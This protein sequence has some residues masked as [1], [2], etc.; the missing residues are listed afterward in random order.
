VK[1]NYFEGDGRRQA[2]WWSLWFLQC[3]SWIFWIDLC[4]SP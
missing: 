1:G 3:Q 2:S 4:I